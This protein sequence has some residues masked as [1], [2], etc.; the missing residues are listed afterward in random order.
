MPIRT[1]ARVIL[2]DV[3]TS[4]RHRALI[5]L[6]RDEEKIIALVYSDFGVDHGSGF[7]ISGSASHREEA[8]VNPLAHHDE[9]HRRYLLR[10]HALR[11]FTARFLNLNI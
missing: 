7:R 8:G 4:G 5:H 1:D 3:I 11:S 10:I 2:D 9:G 6:L